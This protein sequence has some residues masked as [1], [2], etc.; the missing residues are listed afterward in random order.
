[1]SIKFETSTEVESPKVQ[2]IPANIAGD[3]QCNID[4]YFNVYTEETSDKGNKRFCVQLK[5]FLL[6]F[7]LWLGFTNSIRGFPMKGVQMKVP[8]GFL[9]VVMQETKKTLL[10]DSE[11]TFKMSG[12]F[13]D[14]VY[15]NY[16]KVPSNNDAL[17]RATTWAAI[18]S[19]INTVLKPE[20]L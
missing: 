10:E 14:F 17:H 9:G 16:D 19:A 20:D 4:K 1:M 11:R 18:S 5:S 15:W 7:N 2:F 13:D 3:G 8:E 12:K 6:N